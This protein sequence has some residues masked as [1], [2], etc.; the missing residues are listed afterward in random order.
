MANHRW[1]SYCRRIDFE[2]KMKFY[3]RE[4]PGVQSDLELSVQ[5]ADKVTDKKENLSEENK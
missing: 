1:R 4:D 3:F 2:V 5:I